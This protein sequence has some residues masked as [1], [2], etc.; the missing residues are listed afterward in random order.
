M[1]YDVDASIGGKLA[2]IGSR[3]VDAASATMADRFFSAFA[4]DL[5]AKH[6]PAAGA[7]PIA[8]ARAPGFFATLWAFLRRLFAGGG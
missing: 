5:A 2:Q 6:P 8:A 4:A 1:S 3:L 7:A